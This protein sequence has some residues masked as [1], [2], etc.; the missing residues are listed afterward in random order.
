[1]TI[2]LA[3][4]LRAEGAAGLLIGAVVA[5][6][7]LGQLLGTSLAARLP[8]SSHRLLGYLALGLPFVACFGA[9]LTGDGPWVV[10]SAGA[11]G[12]SVSLSK[13][14]LDAALQQHVPLRYLGTA[15]SR[16][17]TALQLFWVLG[18]AIAVAIPTTAALGFGIATALPVLGV[19]LAWQLAVRAPSTGGR[20]P[21]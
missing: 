9:A 21:G 8:E 2:F 4:L 10:A 6:A 13:F 20:P 7:A 5:A 12:M 16:S 3:F 1:M 15:F 14:S 11:T 19:V 17:E 18:G